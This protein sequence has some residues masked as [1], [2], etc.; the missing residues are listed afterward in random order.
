[1]TSATVIKN[2]PRV[3]LIIAI[4]FILFLVAIVLIPAGA[5]GNETDRVNF[6]DGKTTV[7]KNATLKD[8]YVEFGVP[9]ASTLPTTTPPT[10]QTPTT[11]TPTTR[12]P[13]TPSTP[14]G[15]FQIVGKTIVDPEGYVFVPMGANIAV[16]Q[17][18]H[19]E[20]GFAFNWRG[21]A[22]GHSED[23]KAWGW[24]TLRLNVICLT[25]NDGPT[26]AQ[27]LDG[28]D[29]VIKEY[30]AKKIV[31]IIEC[32]H[33]DVT[34]KDPAYSSSV[35]QQ[36]M[37]FFDNVTKKYKNNPYVWF[38]PL[39]EP[40]GSG[41]KAGWIELHNSLYNRVRSNAENNIFIADLPGYGNQIEALVDSNLST[42]SNGKC[43]VLY[44]WHAYGFINGYATDS[45]IKN[46]IEKLSAKNI[47]MIVGE[48]G[49]PLSLNEGTA[50]PPIQNRIG[51]NGVM[52]YAPNY[53]YG[54]LWWHATGDSSNYLTYS[55]TKDRTAPWVRDT[56]NL[57]DGGKTFWEISHRS[58][59]R[60]KFTGSIQGCGA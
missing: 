45:S 39:N 55:L 44:G 54:L 7:V 35:V 52:K 42:Y 47:P 15:K 6:A 13:S 31:I 9:S 43:N 59:T 23:V 5:S 3:A 11:Q 25:P 32:H 21:T 8:G 24:N 18:P 41:N 14:T 36:T 20:N 37:S 53:G 17:A 34:G 51:A 4:A 1:M 57:S 2:R 28:I 12:T 49:D 30:T 27:T 58:T 50:G 40:F 16:R 10:T 56:S 38:N 60:T 46:Y 22:N 26:Q 48:F 19:L 33:G 29:Q